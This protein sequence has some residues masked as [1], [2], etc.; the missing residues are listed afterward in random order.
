MAEMGMGEK[1][2]K[3]S[4]GGKGSWIRTRTSGD[5]RDNHDRIFGNSENKDIESIEG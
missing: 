3:E 4:D 1:R 5:Y 2:M